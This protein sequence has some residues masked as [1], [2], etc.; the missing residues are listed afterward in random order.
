MANNIVGSVAAEIT[1]DTEQFEDAIKRLKGDVEDIKNTFNKKTGGK[2]GLVDDVKQLKEE[3]DSLKGKISDYKNSIKNLRDENSKYADTIGK[4]RKELDSVIKSQSTFNNGLKEEQKNL[5][6]AAKSASKYVKYADRMT[7]IRNN[8]LKT[9]LYEWGRGDLTWLG[10]GATAGGRHKY[11]DF[12]QW[13]KMINT[14]KASISSIKRE[15]LSLTE[16]EIKQQ[17]TLEGMK[18]AYYEYNRMVREAAQKEK[19]AWQTRQSEMRVAME[20]F[21]GMTRN[22]AIEQRKAFASE[23]GYSNLI[24][25]ISKVRAEFGKVNNVNFTKLSDNIYKNGELILSMG[26]SWRKTQSDIVNSTTLIKTSFKQVGEEVEVIK[27]KIGMVSEVLSTFNFKLVEMA[28]KESVAAKRAIELA[29]AMQRMNTQG[30]GSWQGRQVTGGYSNYVSQSGQIEETLKKQ[31]QAAKEAKFA[32][33]GLSQAYSKINLNSYKANLNQINQALEQQKFRTAQLE[34]AQASLFY[35][36]APNNL[37]TYKMNMD[38]INQ[39]LERQTGTYQKNNNEIKRGQMSMREFG[40]T[41]GKA[42]AYSNN[43]YRGLQKVRSV[44]VSM[45]TIMA[46]FGGMALWGFASDLIEGAKESYKAKSEMESLLNQNSHV[47]ASGQKEFNEQL[48]ETVNQFKRINK[49]SL[50]ETAAS[51]GMEFNLNGKQMAKSLDAIAM[52][53]SEYARAGR[54]DQEAALAVKD[55]LQGEFRRLSME[56]GIGEEELTGK[57]GW[58]GEKEDIEGL[59]DALRKAG[60]DRHWDLFAEKATSVGDIVNITKS[61]FSEFGAD[62][63]SNIEPMLVGGFNGIIEIIDSVKGAFEGMSSIGKLTTVA[64]V[65][66]GAFMGISTALMVLK[67]NMGLADMATIGWGKSFM[68]A[69]MGLNKTDVALHGFNKTLLATISGTDAATVANNGFGKSLVAKLL[70]LNQ[71]KVATMGLSKALVA[72]K[73]ALKGESLALSYAELN[74]MKLS[75]KLAYL[76]G[77]MSLADAKSAGLGKSLRAVVT[78]T[79]LLRIAVLGLTGVAILSW[80]AGVVA[81]TER[82][83]KAMDNFNNILSNGSKISENAQKDIDR[84]TDKLAGLT[85]GTKKYN[86]VASRLETAKLNKK[87]ID[88]ANELL[89]IHEREYKSQQKSIEERRKERFKDSLKL[90][91]DNKDLPLTDYEN[92]MKA[93]IDVRNN[94]LKV[95]DD[96][97]YSASQHVNEHIDLMKKAGVDEEKRVKYAREYLLESEQTAKLWKQFNE[98]DLKSGFYAMLSEAKLLWIDLWNNEHFVNFWNEVKKTWQELKPTLDWLV[99]TLGDLGNIMLDFFSTDLGKNIG[100]IG[101]FGGAIG[102]VGTKIGKFVTG[103]KSTIEFLGKLKDKLDIG[104]KKWKWWGDKAEEA[105][106]KIPK[107]STGGITGDD[108]NKKL[109]KNRSEWWT[110]TKGQ[111]FQDATK[112][113]RA[114]VGI[115]AGMA[116]ITEA[117]ALLMLPMGALA[118]TGWTFQQLEPQIRKGIDGLKLIAPV[119]AVLLPPVIALSYLFGKYGIEVSTILEGAGRAAV[120]IAVGIGLVTEAIGLLVGPLL[121]LGAVGWVATQLGDNVKRGVEAMKLV[122]ESLQYLLPFVPA[123]AAGLLLGLAIFESGPIG[124]ALT[125]AAFL[126]VAIGIGLVTEAIFALQAPLWALGELGNNFQD[127]SNVQQGAEAVK[128]TAE[129]LGYVNDAMTSLTGIDLNL[130]A[131]NIATVVSNW[132]G[133]DLGGNLTSLTGEGGVIPQLN[134]F[135]QDFNKIEFTPIDQAKVQALATAGD[136]VGTVGTAMQQVKTAMD[137]L[138]AEFKNNNTGE[139]LGL[140]GNTPPTAD[141]NVSAGYTTIGGEGGYFDAF[142]EPIKQLKTFV[143]DFNN[144]EEFNVQPIDAAKV[145]A[146]SSAADMITQINTAVENVKT[147]MQNVGNAQWETSYAEGG[148][149]AAAGNFLYHATGLDSINNGSSSGSYKSSLGSSLQA[150]ED[151]V[152]DMFT[153]QSRISQYGGE[154][155]GESTDV[156]GVASIVTRVQEAISNLSQTLSGAVPTMEGHGKSI[157]SAIVNGVKAGMEGMG[158]DI[159]NKVATAIDAAKPTA[160]TYGK[161][162]GW[163]VQNGFKNELK[164]QEAL[165][166]EVNNALNSIG[167]DKAQEFYNKGNALGT[168]FANGFKDGSGIHSPGYAAQAMESEIGYISQY[169]NNGIINLPSLASQLGNALSSNFNLDFNLS[170]IQLPDMTQWAYKLSGAIPIVNDVKTQVSSKFEGMKTN[171]QG[172]FNSILSKTRTTMTNMKSATIGHIGN[173]KSS[174]HGMQDALIASADHIKSQTSQKID[175]LKNNL[176]DFWNKV[177]HPDQLIASAAGPMNHQGSIRR[178]SRPHFH[179][180]QGNY[181]GGFDF[182]P[183]RSRGQPSD[184]K[185][186]YLKCMIETGQPCYAGW[187]FNWTNKIANKFKGWNT[188]FAK[189]HLDDYLNVGKFENSNF[190]VKGNAEVAKAYIYDVIAATSYGS[191]FNSKFGD[192]PVAALRAG[193]FNCWDGANIILALARAFGFYGSMGHGSWNGIGHVWASIPGL[194]NIDATAIQNGYGFTSPK[195]SGYAGTIKRGSAS[196]KVPDGNIN[197]TTHNEVHIHINGDVYGIDDLNSKIEEGANRVARQLFRDSYSGV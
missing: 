159:S 54:T 181:A 122:S 44:I 170:N 97:L 164:I 28:D 101:L 171:V 21:V 72:H 52:I 179:I 33:E 175:K 142:K 145:S 139:R 62:L 6:N 107:D 174:W 23:G 149:F 144:S 50:G 163:N 93:A 36:N 30:A 48:D 138:P 177:K 126:G 13:T 67:R 17:A 178:R 186:E 5:D 7:K 125:G 188:H 180:P 183:K 153:F 131:Q 31:T 129:A 35:K 120:G 27:T 182:K 155:G 81:Y 114:A 58:S 29:S 66:G 74:S 116:L 197:K 119:M 90:A 143:D 147:A 3:I 69:L 10:T 56:T 55:I 106:K 70:G 127:L 161:G 45:K 140:T 168:A 9:H 39:S 91:S 24:N 11:G 185:D 192:D 41:M 109:P 160:A 173:I 148:I 43:L 65:G 2:N 187:G 25:T 169:L 51:I 132:L 98:G 118:A 102:I 112:Y 57:Y 78:S 20:A 154:G 137:N 38:Q 99:K 68:T 15:F 103:S 95:Y 141:T 123:F 157:G 79:K 76:A 105:G 165:S 84:Y 156:G 184:L 42:E 12:S 92:Q 196:S 73:A 158:S 46:A 82:C 80:F 8:T 133:V 110:D 18:N 26:E 115:A 61:R 194:G 83:K 47:D 191:Y 130:L 59:M 1:L 113:A 94:A 172:S 37:N 151:I 104:G 189:F 111:I 150:M 108:P 75:Q 89:K 87:D 77:N 53:Q 88:A 86:K 64:G 71:N 134:Q 117:I 85:E 19:L 63:I 14:G 176:G 124:L 162:L 16:T 152:S 195:V 4:L 100:L 128:L 146:I 167:D 40:T 49:Y 96:R 60:K 22:M 136:G 166:T 190:P 34:A 121:A 193:V 135:A 32:T